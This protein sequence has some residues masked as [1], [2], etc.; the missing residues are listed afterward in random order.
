MDVDP[1]G[2][3][4]TM[5]NLP[6]KLTWSGGGHSDKKGQGC[7]SYLIGVKSHFGVS[8]GVEP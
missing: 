8:W 3:P 6:C 4:P 2:S 5:V 1:V 7:S